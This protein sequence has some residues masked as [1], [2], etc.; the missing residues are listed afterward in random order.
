MMP[1]VA[2]LERLLKKKKQIN[3]K[4]APAVNAK[5]VLWVFVSVCLKLLKY[6][7]IKI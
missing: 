5:A 7:T 6:H 2:K 4:H 1:N 3:G